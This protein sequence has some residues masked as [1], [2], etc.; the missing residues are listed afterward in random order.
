MDKLCFL[1]EAEQSQE[2]MQNSEWCLTATHTVVLT[3]GK[4]L[5][6]KTHTKKQEINE[7]RRCKKT[8]C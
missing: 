3:M 8:H 1:C 5:E 7:A 2:G 6:V 4:E